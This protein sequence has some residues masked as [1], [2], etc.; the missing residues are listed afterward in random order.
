MKLRREVAR[1]ITRTEEMYRGGRFHENIGIHWLSDHDILFSRFEGPKGEDRAIYRRS[2]LT[3]VE[4][5]LIG[6]TR[7]RDADDGE[8]VEDQGVSPDGNRLAWVVL[9][10]GSD[11]IGTWLHRRIPSI[12][13]RTWIKTAVWV[14]N[15][16]GSRMHEL[17]CISGTQKTDD[18]SPEWVSLKWLP[19]GK[20]L[21]FEYK[22]KLYT[23][24]AQ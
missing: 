23:V 18:D 24:A 10:R 3:G 16:D 7:A 12:K 9:A 5:K 17:G 22:D 15:L 14:S 8:V 4:T 6:L 11:T 1:F 20:Q 21:S 19:G 2:V 13:P